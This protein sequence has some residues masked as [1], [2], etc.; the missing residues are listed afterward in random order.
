MKK[1][2]PSLIA[3]AMYLSI[4]ATFAVADTSGMSESG[5]AAHHQ[6]HSV[7]QFGQVTSNSSLVARIYDS[8]IAMVGDTIFYD[9]RIT[10]ICKNAECRK[11][12]FSKNM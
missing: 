4:G 10:M 3:V 6:K 1:K 9:Y 5:N 8:K 2:L 12:N 7:P 11:A